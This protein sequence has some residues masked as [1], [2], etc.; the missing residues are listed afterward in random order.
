MKRIKCDICGAN[1][2][3]YS[4]RVRH[5]SDKHKD[6][7]SVSRVSRNEIAELDSVP[8]PG[9]TGTRTRDT[10]SVSQKTGVSP[11]PAN[12]NEELSQ[13]HTEGHASSSSSS[14]SDDEEACPV[15]RVPAAFSVDDPRA[16]ERDAV[17][18]IA[19]HQGYLALGWEQR[20]FLS[21]K[22][23]VLSNGNARALS[24]DQAEK[25]YQIEAVIRGLVEADQQEAET[26]KVSRHTLDVKD[27][28][29]DRAGCSYC[30]A[31]LALREIA[32]RNW[33]AELAEGARFIAARKLRGR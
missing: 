21:V 31:D 23:T 5:I 6:T 7:L 16:Q 28:K 14:S 13:G 22:H 32:D 10:L 11:C 25:L 29:H 30:Q 2:A 12:E 4:A 17:L 18:F 19:A 9:H 1:C 8:A 15:S 26:M 27:P 33:E 24:R 20:F 3:S